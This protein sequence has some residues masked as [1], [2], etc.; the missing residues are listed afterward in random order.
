MVAQIIR[1]DILPIA[2][3]FPRPCEA[4]KNT[5]LLGNI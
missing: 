1:I 3:V 4:Q 2:H 5:A